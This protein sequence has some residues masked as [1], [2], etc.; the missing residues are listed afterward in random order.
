M[1]AMGMDFPM[2]VKNATLIGNAV[3]GAIFGVGMAILG[4]C[5]GTAVGAVGDGSR[6]AV[7]GILGGVVGA[8]IY[9]ETYPWVKATVLRTDFGKATAET[10]TGLSP[11]WFIAGLALAAALGFALLERWERGGTRGEGGAAPALVP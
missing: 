5:P 11:W 8:A 2:H 10:V 4:Y 7:F 6:H 3:G 9:A 1:R